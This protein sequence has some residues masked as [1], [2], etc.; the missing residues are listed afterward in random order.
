MSITIDQTRKQ[1]FVNQA[2]TEIIDILEKGWGEKSL[3]FEKLADKT[4]RKNS[5]LFLLFWAELRFLYC[6]YCQIFATFFAT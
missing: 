3:S 5:C 1:V 6:T 2:T 4:F